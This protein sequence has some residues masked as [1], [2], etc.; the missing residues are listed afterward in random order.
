MLSGRSRHRPWWG[1]WLAHPAWALAI[2]V[3]L[4]LCAYYGMTRLTIQTN[5]VDLLPDDQ[6]EVI[7]LKHLQ[8]IVGGASFVV[9]TFEGP[10]GTSIPPFLET[11]ALRLRANPRVRYLDYRM[12]L[13][14]LRQTGL[15]YLSMDELNAFADRIERRLEQLKLHNFMI[16]LSDPATV[17]R[18]DDLEE[19][20]PFLR[21]YPYYQNAAGTL[22]VMLI[23]PMGRAT[24]IDFTRAFLREIRTSIAETR[25]ALGP[26]F[27]AQK[28]TIHLTGPYV[29]ALT[30]TSHVTDDARRVT[31]VAFLGM[32][33]ILLGYFRR[34]RVLVVISLPLLAGICWALGAAYLFFGQLNFFTAVACAVLMGLSADFGIHLWSHYAAYRRGGTAPVEAISTTIGALWRPMGLATLT[35]AAAFFALAV[36]DFKPLYQ[37]GVIS[38]V[39]ICCMLGAMLL[40]FPPLAILFDH[41]APLPQNVTPTRMHRSAV[42]IYRWVTRPGRHRWLTAISLLAGIPALVGAIQF[43]YNYGNIMGSQTTRTLDDR[44]DRIFSYS[45][46]PEIAR[47]ERPADATAFATAIR[48]AQRAA[49]ATGTRTTIQTAWALG[50]FVPTHQEEKIA[51][52][53][54]LRAA[55]QSPLL[56]LMTDEERRVYDRLAPS[57][58]PQPVTADDLPEEIIT[59]FRDLHGDA[60]K[61]LYIFPRFD[62]QNGEALE[63]FVKELR[64]VEC[65]TCQ[66]RVVITGESIV[67]YEIIHR[68]LREGRIAIMAS[69]LAVALA[70]FIAFRQWTHMVRCLVPLALG[71]VPTLGL[72]GLTGTKF[73]LVNIAAIPVLLG[74]GIDYVI[75][76]YQQLRQH[77]PAHGVEVYQTI[78]PPVIASALTTIC[79]FGALLTADNNGAISFGKVAALGIG[80]SALMTLFWFPGWMASL[81][82]RSSAISP[83]AGGSSP[84]SSQEAQVMIASS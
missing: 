26:D 49:Q 65:L 75:Y 10:A 33:L 15:L 23:K 67:F 84:S 41:I 54:G 77:G 36:S 57:L 4:T 62:R 2:G 80:S 1:V 70:L 27:S 32:A 7:E 12:P 18:I 51:R 58:T 48:A 61:F 30:Q 16:D 34:K 29:K 64:A 22:Y 74:T 59:K 66:D 71:I 52:I 28:L 20:Y 19:Q 3:V 8:D 14:F 76:Y 40:L 38:G 72:M 43:D 82:A 69:L 24:D 47:A 78:A 56:T 81:A 35:T 60:G 6:P 50:D 68:L 73:T 17:L 13:P 53:A 9:V 46:N 83:A 25:H 21:E 44:V 5:F 55:F 63:Q 11:L 37:F 79:G 39:G 45:I 42:I 31:M